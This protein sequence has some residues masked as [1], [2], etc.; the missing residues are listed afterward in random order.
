MMH[1]FSMFKS[2]WGLMVVHLVAFG[3]ASLWNTGL[4]NMFSTA[5]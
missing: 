1:G 5:A 4:E 3:V 2:G